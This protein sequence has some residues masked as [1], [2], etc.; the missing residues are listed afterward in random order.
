MIPTIFFSLFV[1][2]LIFLMLAL[3]FKDVVLGVIAGNL[4]IV[5]G[6]VLLLDGVDIKI[7]SNTTS[8]EEC[9]CT[10]YTSRDLGTYSGK[11]TIIAETDLFET[12]K[13]NLFGMVLIFFGAYIIWKGAIDANKEA[14]QGQ[15]LR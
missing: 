5:L 6:G 9:N 4:F 3:I 15:E 12:F 8:I 11:Q 1:V 7:G 2:A 13:S 14:E 10:N